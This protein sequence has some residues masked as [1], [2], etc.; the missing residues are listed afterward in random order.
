[1]LV[2]LN[3]VYFNV[4]AILIKVEKEIKICVNAMWQIHVILNSGETIYICLKT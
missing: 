3:D 2:L 4:T 1:M